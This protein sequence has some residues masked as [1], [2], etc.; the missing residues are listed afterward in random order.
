MNCKKAYCFFK[1][2]VSYLVWGLRLLERIDEKSQ[3]CKET[4]ADPHV[5][6]SGEGDEVLCN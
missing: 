5:R 3:V 1:C 4:L 6:V 2:V